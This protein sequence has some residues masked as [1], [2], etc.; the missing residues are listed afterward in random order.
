MSTPEQRKIYSKE[1]RRRPENRKRVNTQSVERVKR[2]RLRKNLGRYGITIQE[3]NALLSSQ[4]NVCALC[5]R[6]PS[7]KRLSVDHEHQ[8]G[9]KNVES[10]SKRI[11]IRGLLCHRCNRAIGFLSNDTHGLLINAQR[12]VSFCNNFLSGKILDTLNQVSLQKMCIKCGLSPVR[13]TDS[14]VCEKCWQDSIKQFI[15]TLKE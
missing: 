9:D 8:K 13:K 4:D 10:S 3:Y 11:K 7:R 5:G 15:E 14:H 2:K 12:L 1:W 6:P